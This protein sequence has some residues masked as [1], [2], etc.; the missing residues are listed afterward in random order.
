MIAPFTIS[1][2]SDE[3]ERPGHALPAGATLVVVAALMSDDLAATLQRL[4][5]EGHAVHVVKTSPGEWE[6]ALSSIPVTEIEPAMRELEAGETSSK[7][8][9]AEAA[10]R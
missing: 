6:V 8:P 3:L 9:R 10:S 7:E 4:R 1:S 5:S 2:L